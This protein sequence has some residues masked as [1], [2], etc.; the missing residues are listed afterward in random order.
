M[1]STELVVDNFAGGGGASIGIEAALGSRVDLA[2]NHDAEAIRMHRTN[3]PGTIHFEADIWDVDPGEACGGIPVGL[4]WFSPD[5]KHFSR[6]KGTA[7][8]DSKIRGLAWVVTRW[9]AKVR[10]R[11]IMLENVA[12]FETWGPL[13]DD[14]RPIPT[15]KGATFKLWVG[16]LEK[17][18]Y[19]VEWR[20][21][22]ACD[23]GAPTT[24]KRLFLVARCDGEPI[25]W[26]LH[27]HGPELEPHRT[28]EGII[29]WSLPCPSVF[30]SKEEGKQHGVRRPLAEG[31]HMRIAM[32]VR[33]FVID[34]QQPFIVRH[35][36]YSTRT[37]AGLIP[38]CG[39]GVFRGQSLEQ[40]L[41]T[42]CATNDKNLVMPHLLKHYGGMVGHELT[43]PIGTVTAIDHHSL[44]ASLLRHAGTAGDGGRG[45]Q[46]FAFLQKYYGTPSNGQDVRTP[47][48]TVRTKDCFSL[49]EVAGEQYRIDDIGMRMLSPIELYRAQG[50]PST[51]KIE[52][53]DEGKPFTKKAQTKLAGNSVCP[54]VARA[55]VSANVDLRVAEAA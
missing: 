38:G 13:D 40:P 50:F 22:H 27:T 12:E 48:H 28:A 45:G 44:S 23:Y 46:V 17:M 47:L 33:R 49:V 24:R 55:L 37:G 16:Q 20:E 41:A 34:A 25:T 6:A 11:I 39:A 54:D 32:G 42:V 10:P 18:G 7:P 35:G 30:L 9:A 29:D 52:R 14:G 2:I 21:L 31:T 4:A 8:V 26:P 1:K 3:H 43:R 53:D 36:H 19:Q 5:C 51:Y 15:E